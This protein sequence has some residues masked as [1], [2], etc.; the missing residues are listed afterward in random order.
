LPFGTDSSVKFG[1]YEKSS[2]VIISQ[3][4]HLLANDSRAQD[5]AKVGRAFRNHILKRE[6]FFWADLSSEE[7][8]NVPNEKLLHLLTIRRNS[9][10]NQCDLCAGH[11]CRLFTSSQGSVFRQSTPAPRD[12]G[13]EGAPSPT[14][15][16]NNIT[17]EPHNMETPNSF[18]TFRPL[19]TDSISLLALLN[20]LW[21]APNVEP[22]FQLPQS[23]MIGDTALSILYAMKGNI[24][25]L[26]HLFELG[27][28]SPVD[29]SFSRGFTLLR[30]G[31]ANPLVHRKV[32]Q[33]L[34][35][36]VGALWRNG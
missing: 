16:Y 10:G 23:R 17:D 12:V 33:T 36:L 26:K 5:L 29:A 31:L 7:I 22:Q 34:I 9:V 2:N 21:D 35:V 13:C 20:T 19:Q 8:S 6:A 3:L 27:L 18:L 14:T 28:A 30:V 25:G 15:Q 1:H 4:C 24:E 32:F 11:E